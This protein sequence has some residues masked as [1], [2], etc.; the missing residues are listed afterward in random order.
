VKKTG[1]DGLWF[2]DGK[3]SG[4]KFIMSA[5]IILIITG[6]SKIWSAFGTAKLLAFPDPITGVHFGYLILTVGLVE[7]IIAAT[8]LS[9]KSQLLALSLIAWMATNLFLY[10]AGLWWIGWVRPCSCLG[11]LADS[12]HIT[13]QTANNCLKLIL[14]YLLIGSYGSLFWL[15]RQRKKSSSSG[16]T[17]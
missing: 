13:P 4:A 10:R 17:M 6:F 15:W 5:A 11:N 12:L 3:K 16:A 14:A 2:S 8:C 1:R 7:L 9:I